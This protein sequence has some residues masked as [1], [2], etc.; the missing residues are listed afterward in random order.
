MARIFTK[1]DLDL[2][3]RQ[4]DT[5]SYNE[6]MQDRYNPQ[7][8][9]LESVG[10]GQYE[11]MPDSNLP[12]DTVQDVLFPKK[13]INIMQE[14]ANR[15]P[16]DDAYPNLEEWQLNPGQ[17]KV[18]NV[19]MNGD[20]SFVGDALG[21]GGALGSMSGQ[22]AG[23]DIKKPAPLRMLASKQPAQ[24]EK[25]LAEIP[26]SPQQA[27]E[28]MT[29]D[30]GD[31]PLNTQAGLQDALNKRDRSNLI[32]GV[33]QSL[34]LLGAGISG[35]KPVQNPIFQSIE[36]QAGTPIDDF[37]A[38]LEM[39]KNDPKSG[40][41]QGFKNYLKTLGLEIKGDL[42]AMQAEKLMPAAFRHY[43]AQ[44][45]QDLKREMGEK[46]LG[47]KKEQ[48][49]AKSEESKA[50][51]AESGRWHDMLGVLKGQ[52]AD[53]KKEAAQVKIDDKTNNDFMK[54]AEK[55]SSAKASSR[56]AMGKAALNKAAAERIE[57]LF[58]G[59]NL[60]YAD[61]REVAEASR[62]LDALLAQGQATIT[63]ARE[64]TPRTLRM[65]I[66]EILES[67][68]NTRQPAE[69][70]SFLKQTLKTVRRE[71]ELANTQLASYQQQLIPG[72]EHLAKK[73]PERWERLIMQNL[74]SDKEIQEESAGLVKIKDKKTGRIK[75]FS[76]QDA[77]KLLSNP[78]KFEQVQ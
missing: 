59:R 51:L 13:K 76:K 37:N 1:E 40:V 64:L 27:S 11:A 8:G 38:K 67:L 44:L 15:S 14:I 73:D 70:A 61:I 30:F 43:E 9:Q 34:D 55:F 10:S 41:S 2:L 69:A 7:T 4:G 29:V 33:G 54:A 58:E 36:R 23:S 77:T 31:Q 19:P 49:S 32:A 56:S 50:K 75:G 20:E 66:A 74:P 21:G 45:A 63:G 47:F 72:F 17:P 3:R 35:A 48:L 57:K 78:D 53:A 46:E 52:Q 5:S 18:G 62:S 65:K 60:N 68:T 26:I 71:K 6:L 39:E 24:Q 12:A 16:A 42:T 28:Q 22:T 25:P